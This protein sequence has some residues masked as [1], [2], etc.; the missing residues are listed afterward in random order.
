M[1]A[2]KG[3]GQDAYDSIEDVDHLR[4]LEGEL[5]SL[6][7]RVRP[8]VVLLRLGGMRGGATGTGVLISS[9]GL[10]A[11]CGHV[12]ER[13]GRRVTATLSD[14][15]RLSGRTLGQAN[16]GMLDCG[17]IQLDT[18]G[19]DLPCAPLG[20]SATLEPGDWL[21]ALGFT[22]G[23]PDR[24]RPALVRV[25]RV[26]R[27]TPNEMLFDAP[28]DAGDSGGPSFNLRG[29]VVAINSRCGHQPWENAATPVDRLRDRMTEFQAG[30]DEVL[31]T[32]IFTDGDDRSVRT[33]FG[34]SN[35]GAGRMAVQRDLPLSDVTA[36]VKASMVRVMD[37][38]SPRCYGTVIDDLGHAVTKR[39]QLPVGWQKG[40]LTVESSTGD[41]FT[42]R[43]VGVD[44]ALDLAVLAIA[45]CTLPAVKWAIDQEVQPGEVLLTPRLGSYTPALGFA[46]IEHR[47]SMRDWSTG[48][49]LGV[50]TSDAPRKQREAANLEHALLVEEVVP[51]SGADRAG[52][53][54]GDLIVSL[55][56][57]PVTD[58]MALRETIA[59]RSTGDTL[60]IE[61]IRGGERIT[62]NATLS[63]RDPLPG[64]EGLRGNTTTPIS[65]V[66]T[67]FGEVIAHDAIVWPEQC[68]GPVV[69]LEGRAVGLNIARFDRTATHAILGKDVMRAVTAVLQSQPAS[70]DQSQQSLPA[71]STDAP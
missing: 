38:K 50:R 49:Y 41:S 6:A 58:R 64:K 9:D 51:K 27:I 3:V 71:K 70:L 12:G 63:K 39:S 55:D 24:D 66:S 43:V 44:R 57:E 47:E 21:L 11:T 37:G 23:P 14:G 17:L 2:E 45:D 61:L 35:S 67:G 29:E 26:L 42:A 53:L 15:T 25:G 56:D 28:I 36:A 48:P 69:N 7:T 34:R 31:T 46:A 22:Q 13:S 60:A 62:V 19:R 1:S 30:T 10:V 8:S 20:T 33:D 16:S 4:Q 54:V 5:T 32:A 52:V 65:E 68:G 59:N 18:E 40:E